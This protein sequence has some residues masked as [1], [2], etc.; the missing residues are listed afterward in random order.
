MSCGTG[1]LG[2]VDSAGDEGDVCEA[3]G[4]TEDADGAG[5]GGGACGDAC[6]VGGAE[7]MSRCPSGTAGGGGTSSLSSVQS[8]GPW[9]RWTTELVACRKGKLVSSKTT[10][11]EV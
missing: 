1:E 7:G 5:V 9:G 8:T 10:W 11:R 4:G 2:G 6:A 3:A